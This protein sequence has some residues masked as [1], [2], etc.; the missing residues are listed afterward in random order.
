MIKFTRD[1]V[2]VDTFNEIFDRIVVGLKIAYGDDITVDQDSPDG[3]SIGIQAKGDLDL[4]SFLLALYSNFDPD[5][6]TGTMQ[7]VILK[8]SGLTRRPPTKST[9]DF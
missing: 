5:F 8:F 2:S 4:Q 3:Q 9:S 6:A 1:G 7:D